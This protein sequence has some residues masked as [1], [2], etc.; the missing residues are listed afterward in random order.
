MCYTYSITIITFTTMREELPIPAD[1]PE[2]TPEELRGLA[3]KFV[4]QGEP[5]LTDDDVEI[6]QNMLAK[7]HDESGAEGKEL[8]TMLADATARRLKAKK[9][10]A[11]TNPDAQLL[12]DESEVIQMVHSPEEARRVAQEERQND[13][14][15]L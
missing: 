12:M 14:K 8:N 13:N 1:I 2:L 7:M 4:P 5:P 11:P 3:A 9:M 10:V 15:N 6:I